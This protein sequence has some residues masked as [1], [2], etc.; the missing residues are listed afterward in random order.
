MFGEIKTMLASVRPHC[1][2]MA[3]NRMDDFNRDRLTNQHG[4]AVEEIK[5]GER[6]W[7]AV[8]TTVPYKRRK[9]YEIPGV[10]AL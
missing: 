6:I 7:A 2:F 10:R 8:K 3:E 9:D 4:Y 5:E 1:F